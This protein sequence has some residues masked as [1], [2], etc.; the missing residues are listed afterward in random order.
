MHREMVSH[1]VHSF[2]YISAEMK[3][4]FFVVRTNRI[5]ENTIYIHF[6]ITIR[7][8]QGFNLNIVYILNFFWETVKKRLITHVFYRKFRDLSPKSTPV[9]VNL[10]RLHLWWFLAIIYWIK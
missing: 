5:P 10:F 2:Y 1:L 4:I 8:Y 6:L 7:P 3:S 9:F